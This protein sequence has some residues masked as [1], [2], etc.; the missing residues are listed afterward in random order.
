[1]KPTD[2]QEDPVAAKKFYER[3][4]PIIGNLV[5]VH[6]GIM[7]KERIAPV[8][9]TMEFSIESWNVV[10]R[11]QQSRAYGLTDHKFILE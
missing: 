7:S 11:G 1:L 10:T 4:K 6:D 5:E 3:L 9:P 2:L 8:T